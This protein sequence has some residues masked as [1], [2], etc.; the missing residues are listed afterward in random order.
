MLRTKTSLR[1]FSQYICTLPRE[2]NSKFPHSQN[3]PPQHMN[4]KP[5][6]EYENAL[7]VA[8]DDKTTYVFR[9]QKGHKRFPVNKKRT[10]L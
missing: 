2:D 1:S 7:V 6:N 5:T 10:Y 4:R 9:M 3:K 8:E